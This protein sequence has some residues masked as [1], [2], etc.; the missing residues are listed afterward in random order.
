MIAQFHLVNNYL[1]LFSNQF[2]CL[3]RS[4]TILHSVIQSR[5]TAQLID[6]C[7]AYG[8][9][10]SLS[11]LLSLHSLHSTPQTAESAQSLLAAETA[12]PGQAWVDFGGRR[13]YGAAVIVTVTTEIQNRAN[14][15]LQQ[16]QLHR[17]HRASKSMI[18]KEK[19][20]RLRRL[21]NLWK[22]AEKREAPQARVYISIVQGYIV[23]SEIVEN[24]LDF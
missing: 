21:Q 20:R 16:R 17:L 15:A 11:H 8:V 4:Y 18:T 23:Y 9:L 7:I 5:Q 10:H 12:E 13:G 22:S 24:Q 19:Q 2:P 14:Q 3:Y 6:S 1:L